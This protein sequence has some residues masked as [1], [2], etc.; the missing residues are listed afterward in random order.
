MSEH[1]YV[2]TQGSVVRVCVSWV[3][4]LRSDGLDMFRSC[5]WCSVGLDV[6]VLWCSAG[7]D[8]S[9]LWCSAGSNVSV[10]SVVF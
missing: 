6:S 9:V 5:Q 1:D 2:G 10:W 8:V 7:S 4:L 3:V